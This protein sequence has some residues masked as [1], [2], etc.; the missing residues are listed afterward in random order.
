MGI[1]LVPSFEDHNGLAQAVQGTFD[2]RSDKILSLEHHG[3]HEN[4][5]RPGMN[6]QVIGSVVPLFSYILSMEKHVTGVEDLAGLTRIG[7]RIER[8]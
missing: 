4:R 3:H 1:V 6:H 7:N 2:G 8:H 5:K